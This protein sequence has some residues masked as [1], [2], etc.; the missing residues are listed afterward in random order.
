MIISARRI[1]F[2]LLLLTG[3]LVILH[4]GLRALCFFG[5]CG[6][7]LAGIGDRFNVDHETSVP[8]WFSQSI[9]LIAAGLAWLISNQESIDK[10]SWRVITCLLLMM[11][12][13]EG[14]SFHETLGVALG[15]GLG[16]S[17][18]LG[19][20]VLRDWVLLGLCAVGVV[21]AVLWRFISALPAR[22]RRIL[23]GGGAV[24]LSGAVLWESLHFTTFGFVHN[25]PAFLASL[26]VA[27]EEGLEM[28]GSIIVIYGLADYLQNLIFSNNK[29]AIFDDR[30][31]VRDA[32]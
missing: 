28:L 15:Q 25:D 19:V 29:A 17:I 8:T 26:S 32:T 30:T 23:I 16:L 20:V 14:A 7:V 22:T 4:I 1:F 21:G 6:D 24:F 3:V 9:L 10:F 2:V 13:D 31:G 18:H 12:I 11:S 5:G 27:V